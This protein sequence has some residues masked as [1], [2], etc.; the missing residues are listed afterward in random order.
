MFMKEK[1]IPDDKKSIALNVTI[2]SSEK[3]LNDEDLKNFSTYNF[4]CRNKIWCKIRS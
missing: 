2:Q 4:N 1:N 3:T